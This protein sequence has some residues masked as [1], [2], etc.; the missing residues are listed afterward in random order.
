MS[1]SSLQRHRVTL[2]RQYVTVTAAVHPCSSTSLQFQRYLSLNTRT[3]H[4]SF[5]KY[6]KQ[7]LDTPFSHLISVYFL[8]FVPLKLILVFHCCPIF[9]PTVFL[10]KDTFSPHDYPFYINGQFTDAKHKSA[11]RRTTKSQFSLP[12]TQQQL[13]V[14]LLSG[15]IE[16]TNT[17]INI[18]DIF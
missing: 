9:S 7:L 13:H 6:E 16:S 1:V 2:L 15:R 10:T 3:R 4:F 8:K 17:P 18:S 11:S 5:P 12:D 14:P